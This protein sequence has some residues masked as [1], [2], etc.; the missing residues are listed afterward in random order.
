MPDVDQPPLPSVAFSEHVDSVREEG[1]AVANSPNAQTFSMRDAYVFAGCIATG[2]LLS[3][4]HPSFVV[5]A[6]YA[7]GG[8]G[9]IRW[10]MAAR[11]YAPEANRRI[12]N[13]S[14]RASMQHY[15][16]YG[17]K[18]GKYPLALR[19]YGPVK[20]HVE[21]TEA[22]LEQL[23]TM[24]SLARENNIE[25][26]A[27]GKD[28][29]RAL[30]LPDKVPDTETLTTRQFFK[31]RGMHLRRSE[32]KDEM[33]IAPPE[34]W[35]QEAELQKLRRG[36]P[37]TEDFIRVL[38][39]FVPDH[40]LVQVFGAYKKHP[41]ELRRELTKV[42][43]NL[44]KSRLS[45]PAG[46]SNRPVI[47]ALSQ[48][49]SQLSEEEESDQ[50][51]INAL[52]LREGDIS[53]KRRVLSQGQSTD[54]GKRIAWYAEG[55][56]LESESALAALGI[57]ADEI[58]SLLINPALQP[59]KAQKLLELLVYN[60]VRGKHNFAEHIKLPGQKDE[61]F[62]FP[63]IIMA[64]E[65][66]TE[67]YRVEKDQRLSLRTEKNPR[68]VAVIIGGI[69][70]SLLAYKGAI[71]TGLT[72]AIMNQNQ[73]TQDYFS[74]SEKTSGSSR[75]GS[76]F[77][78]QG[79]GKV[80]PV[81]SLFS[82][83]NR[84]LQ[85]E[86]Y[87]TQEVANVVEVNYDGTKR[88]LTW[89]SEDGAVTATDLPK[90]Y[91]AIA[92]HI[93]VGRDLRIDDREPS[94]QD[95]VRVP[96][97][98]GTKPVA[99]KY[100][101]DPVQLITF[102]S[103]VY[104][105]KLADK[106]EKRLTYWLESTSD[107]PHA[108][109][110]VVAAPSSRLSLDKIGINAYWNQQFPLSS[111]SVKRA[112]DMAFYIASN[113]TYELNPP[114]E[115]V[116]PVL[117]ELSSMVVTIDRERRVQCF[118]GNTQ[119]VISNPYDL[120]MASGF[121]NNGDETITNRE[122]HAWG[123]GYQQNP[124]K[125]IVDATPPVFDPELIKYFNETPEDQE[126]FPYIPLGIGAATALAGAVYLRRRQLADAYYRWSDA[127]AEKLQTYNDADLSATARITETLLYAPDTTS[128]ESRVADAIK[129]YRSGSYANATASTDVVRR[130][131][132]LPRPDDLKKRLGLA[133]MKAWPE[134]K[135]AQAVL[136]LVAKDQRRQAA[137]ATLRTKKRSPMKKS[138]F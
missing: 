100:G 28:V 112:R 109:E 32:G 12:V 95:I 78:D 91:A 129:R 45:E 54:N 15:E 122:A 101:D 14:V 62:K 49:E 132:S 37:K 39:R 30:K 136:K 72:Q 90:N 121:R 123:L 96:V 59:T 128:D 60:A 53:K 43:G 1:D 106:S 124:D 103:G 19:W 26:F 64:Q 9:L 113:Y 83:K 108:I 110:P 79:S 74:D 126:R 2:V 8:V 52:F 63:R 89:R 25:Q 138:L 105:F 55:I 50:D 115:A 3:P 107:G 57:S 16:L 88:T 65:R 33:L 76:S 48:L 13:A 51:M 120:N 125:N 44:L 41:E 58:T 67:L 93:E 98:A 38:K 18:K 10:S 29:L 137:R 133:S 86:G 66:A 69:L 131:R 97:K 71:E 68:R 94:N 6:S 73:L 130:L 42:S 81:E 34:R 114:P 87:W 31:D 84:G 99:A 85:T 77:G 116:F 61:S 104:G 35:L 40:P 118:I 127:P 75:S 135:T 22:V 117:G 24:A 102:K 20:E 56:E 5:M 21:S 36:S 47:N 111:D 82:V 46:L 23:S 7:V 80:R 92:P 134:I 119:N 17:D 27:V 11:R 4:A 70:V